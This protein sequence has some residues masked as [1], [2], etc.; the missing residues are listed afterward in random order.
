MLRN[1]ASHPT[2]P[3]AVRQRGPFQDPLQPG[4]L[5]HHALVR[6][7]PP[8]ALPW[9]IRELRRRLYDGKSSGTPA[10]QRI[11]LR[12]G[13]PLWWSATLF[14]LAW[15]LLAACIV[16]GSDLGRGFQLLDGGGGVAQAAAPVF[17][18]PATTTTATA[19]TWNRSALLWSGIALLGISLLLALSPR[20]HLFLVAVKNDADLIDLWV[21]GT[22]WRHE[23][24]FDR[25]FHDLT[26]RIAL[27]RQERVD[28]PPANV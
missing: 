3:S 26:R 11:A 4:D 12:Q 21:S 13:L 17:F 22:S 5:T 2:D 15:F 7:L 28:T 6:D 24:Q 8:H 19:L 23:R 20:K 14:A 10:A 27:H 16:A 18:A 25:E 1:D 9:A